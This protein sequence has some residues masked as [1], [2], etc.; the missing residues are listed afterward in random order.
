[1]ANKHIINVKEVEKRIVKN[2]Q[3]NLYEKVNMTLK[4]I[5][6]LA[7]KSLI[8]E[9]ISIIEKEHKDNIKLL[10]KMEAECSK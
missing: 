7:D 1:M 3:K 2:V 10:K 5:P 6:L 9:M 8:K 4:G